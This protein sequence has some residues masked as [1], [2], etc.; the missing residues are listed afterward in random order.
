ML[1]LIVFR[2]TAISA[3][4][5]DLSTEG[6]EAELSDL[7]ELD[8]EGN[9][10][11][12]QT[13][14]QAYEIEGNI[15]NTAEEEDP[16]HIQEGTSVKVGN[17]SFS[18]RPDNE[19]SNLELLNADGDKD[20][21]DTADDTADKVKKSGDK[22]EK[23]QPKNVSEGSHSLLLFCIWLMTYYIILYFTSNVNRMTNFP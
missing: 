18:E 6:S 12:C 20:K 13:E 2:T 21:S 4:A 11:D 15:A 7:E 16:Y 3:A 14:D 17:D 5:V 8:S 1:A 23:Y 19:L 22:S 9:T 10:D